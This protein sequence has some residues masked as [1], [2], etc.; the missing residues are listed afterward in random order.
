MTEFYNKFVPLFINNRLQNISIGDIIK[1]IDKKKIYEDITTGQSFKLFLEFDS[2][3]LSR[4][5]T[6]KYIIDEFI[7]YIQSSPNIIKISFNDF[8]QDNKHMNTY[9]IIYNFDKQCYYVVFPWL[10]INW[11]DYVKIINSFKSVEHPVNLPRVY[12]VQLI[13]ND[14]LDQ[15]IILRIIPKNH[16]HITYDY[17][18]RDKQI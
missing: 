7:K 14:K 16:L 13:K 15:D 1:Q 5:F 10:T 18:T 11:D 12:Y 4:V 2:K 8:V 9:K 6:L 17:T 3:R